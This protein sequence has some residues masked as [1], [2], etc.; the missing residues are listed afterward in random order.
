[1]ENVE[2][3][4]TL[5]ERMKEFREEVL[6][7]KPYIDAQRAILATLA[8]KENLNQPRVMVRAKMLEKV[9]DNM[10]IYIEDKSLLAGNQATKNRNAPIFP[11]YTMEFV[12]NE[13]DQFEKRDGDVFYITEKTKEQLREI[14]PFWQNN[15]LRARGEALLPEEVRVFMETGVFGMEGKLN[16]GDAQYR[17][18]AG[19]ED[20]PDVCALPKMPSIRDILALGMVNPPGYDREQV[21][22]MST[23]EKLAAIE[24]IDMAMIPLGIH[25]DVARTIWKFLDRRYK[26]ADVM[27]SANEDEKAYEKESFGRAIVL[28][29]KLEAPSPI[30]F[31][32]HGK[33]GC[34]K[35]MAVN[36]ACRMYPNVIY[37]EFED[38]SYVQIPIV[39]VTALRKDI[40]DVFESIA[41]AFDRFLDTGDY[42]RRRAV[43]AKSISATEGL[44]KKWIELYHVGLIIVDEVQFLD[45]SPKKKNIEDIV[46]ITQATGAQFGLIGNDDG[47]RAVLEYD[48]LNRRVAKNIIN[49][50]EVTKNN[51]R[52]FENAIKTLWGYQFGNVE[53]PFTTEIEELLMYH[54]SRNIALLKYIV[55]TIQTKDVIEKRKEPIDV[56]FIEKTIGRD[57]ETLRKLLADPDDPEDAQYHEYIT[58][59]YARQAKEVATENDEEKGRLFDMMAAGELTR[60]REAVRSRAF[61]SISDTSNYTETQ[62][63]RAIRQAI[64]KEPDI[65]D[66]PSKFLAQKAMEILKKANA[67]VKRKNTA[68]ANQAKKGKSDAAAIDRETSQ[69]LTALKKAMNE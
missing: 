24:D 37:H 12:M 25:V 52:L 23:A 53:S 44:V 46:S 62:I 38:C 36:L 67:K 8:Y 40:R 6:D 56:P 9:L 49:A 42:H 69:G 58:K 48:R 22:K 61:Q 39:M 17:R 66:H 60:K 27:I 45:F 14:A 54:S 3:F 10:S 55:I 4:G 26:G 33:T 35:T 13:L 5:T 31:L 30:G 15:N 29:Q 20:N 65:L 68:T 1:M 41:A 64:D 57:M 51:V 2:H 19:Y 63:N 59:L 43:G 47:Y 16:A 32:L 7:E 18:V 50:D 11:E 34:G 21:E 28:Y